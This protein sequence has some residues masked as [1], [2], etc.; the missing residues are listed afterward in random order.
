LSRLF[1]FS[2]LGVAFFCSLGRLILVSPQPEEFVVSHGILSYPGCADDCK[3]ILANNT[4]P[5][6]SDGPG[7]QSEI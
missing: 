6:A 3:P 5:A 1:V 2:F 4:D 7:L